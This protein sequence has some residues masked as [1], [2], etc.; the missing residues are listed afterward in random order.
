MIVE[1]RGGRFR[2]RSSSYDPTSRYR[3]EAERISVRSEV[4]G[5]KE[6]GECGIKS[7]RFEV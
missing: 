7:L 5:K 2:L 3:F 1:K 4:G 6:K